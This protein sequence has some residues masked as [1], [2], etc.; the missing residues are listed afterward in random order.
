VLAREKEER[1]KVLA[2]EKKAD[3]SAGSSTGHKRP[4]LL[5]NTCHA[6]RSDGEVTR[7]AWP[8]HYTGTPAT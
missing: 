3:S 7:K 4:P 1:A 6:F 2:T 8:E 5:L